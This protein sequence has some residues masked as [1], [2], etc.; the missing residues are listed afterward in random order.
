MADPT[1]DWPAI[2][3]PDHPLAQPG[4][5]VL[6]QDDAFWERWEARGFD[7]WRFKKTNRW[8]A[9]RGSSSAAD[10]AAGGWSETVPGA[11]A[12][13]GSSLRSKLES[14]IAIANLCD[15]EGA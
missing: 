8:F 11:L 7:L 13:F 3:G 4:A 2:L 9:S 15:P 6:C 5:L 10:R 1:R 14:L 12:S